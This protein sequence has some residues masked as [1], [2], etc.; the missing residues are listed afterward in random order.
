MAASPPPDDLDG[1][2]LGPM[3]SPNKREQHL[4][5]D[6]EVVGRQ[7]NAGPDLEID[8]PKTALGV[9]ERLPGAFGKAAAHPAINL[10]AQPRDGLGVVHAI[11]DDQLDVGL[12]GTAE[13][14]RQ[15]LRS[16]LPIT[17]HCQAPL[18]SALERSG[19]A[20]LERRALAEVPRM[21]DHRRTCRR[22]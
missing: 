22:G 7:R 14:R 10:P 19:Q 16:V 5:L 9:R 11:A 8:Q 15:V 1:H 4:R 6:L 12:L 21:A 2:K 13:K 17:V 20:G 18:E 3:P